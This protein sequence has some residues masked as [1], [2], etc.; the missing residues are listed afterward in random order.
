[1]IDPDCLHDAKHPAV[2]PCTLLKLVLPGKRALAGSLNEIVGIAGGSR[3]PASETTQP[4]QD[5]DQ[6]IAE[7]DARRIPI[8]NQAYRRSRQSVAK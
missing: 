2:E 7:P 6:L 1:L 4:R 3:E 5:G 8:R